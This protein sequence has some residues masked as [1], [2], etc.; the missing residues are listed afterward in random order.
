ME[1]KKM[2]NTATSNHFEF[3]EFQIVKITKSYKAAA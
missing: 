3:N 1:V 2:F